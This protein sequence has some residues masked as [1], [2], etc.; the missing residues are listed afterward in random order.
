MKKI[1]LP[2]IAF[3]MVA[4]S[5]GQAQSIESPSSAGPSNGLLA[6]SNSDISI[7]PNPTKGLVHI[8]NVTHFEIRKIEVL[9]VLG[10]K[11]KIAF[12]S[13]QRNTIQ[14]DMSSLMAGVYL[15][16][17]SGTSGQDYMRKVIVQ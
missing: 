16:R 9:N 13:G 3:S 14:L 5:Y 15:V 1:L 7:F 10:E 2:L 11:V 4:L 12:A 8:K 6:D 17:L